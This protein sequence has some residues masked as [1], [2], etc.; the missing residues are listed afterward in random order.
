MRQDLI[1]HVD[2]APFG[3]HR[4]AL[5]EVVSRA[6]A[7]ERAELRTLIDARLRG[8]SAEGGLSP[9]S[10]TRVRSP[11]ADAA[12]SIV[13][14]APTALPEPANQV[15]ETSGPR[16]G[17]VAAPPA[18]SPWYRR[19]LPAAV[20]VL[21]FAGAVA[22]VT[23]VGHR[24]S[25]V[26]PSAES[27]TPA[28]PIPQAP[29][30]AQASPAPIPSAVR[31]F[32]RALPD[33]ARLVIDGAAVS[34]PYQGHAPHDGSTHTVV[35]EGPGLVRRTLSFEA[36][37]DTK[38]EI[39]LDR[40]P[41]VRAVGRQAETPERASAPS[42]VTDHSPAV[43]RSAPGSPGDVDTRRAP[44]EVPAP[45]PRRTREVDKENPYAP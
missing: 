11:Y 15:E 43:E 10:L 41:P 18:R 23:R 22:A 2:V 39:A 36:S 5:G 40:A 24:S 8:A 44:A 28:Q 9:I 38:L 7:S 33:T 45:R 6:F 31:V 37:S 26:P 4:R 1:R 25:V 13:T 16:A 35:A 17:E 21:G 20:V 30:S 32:V 19:A 42:P 34:N 12:Q 27:A 14:S 3:D 29:D